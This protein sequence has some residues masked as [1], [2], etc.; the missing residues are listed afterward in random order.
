MKP[1]PRANAALALAL[2]TAAPAAAQDLLTNG[3]FEADPYDNGWAQLGATQFGG[4]APGSTKA[5]SFPALSRIGQN[6]TGASANWQLDFY[7][8]VKNTTNRAFS[9][10]V[11]ATANSAAN[12]S[13]ATIN[14]RYQSGQFNT[15]SGP[16][17]AWSSD[18]G[19]GSVAFSTDANND[20]DFDDAGDVKNVYRMRLTGSGW[21][22]GNG[23]YK[24]Q[25]SNANETTFSRTTTD[26]NRYQNGS[27]NTAV[28]GAFIFNSLFGSNPG[29][30]VDD[31]T[32]ENIV[33]PD[34]PNLAVTSALPIFGT[35]P[36]GATGVTSRNVTVQNTGAANN[37]TITAAAFTGA[38]ASSFSTTATFPI[39]IAPGAT[40]DIPVDFNPGVAK[41]AFSA[42]LELT[43]DDTS[44]AVTPVNLPVH[45]YTAGDSLITDGTFEPLPFPTPWITTGTVSAVAGLRAGSATAAALAGPASGGVNSTAGLAVIGP[46]DWTLEFDTL[47]LTDTGRA[48]QLLVHNFGEPNRLDGSTF[49]LRYEAGSFATLSGTT[50]WVSRPVLGQMIPSLDAN[51]DGDYD[52][53]GD[54]KNVYRIRLSGS[55]WASAAA[56]CSI[57]VSE[58]NAPA[59]TRFDADF[60]SFASAGAL[61]SAPTS[62]LFSTAI[63]TNPGFVV[64]NV[65]MTAGAPA[66]VR[67]YVPVETVSTDGTGITLSWV[68]DGVSSYRVWASEN[69][70]DWT[71]LD[72]D[73]PGP[74]YTDAFTIDRSRRF[75]RVEKQ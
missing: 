47:I 51:T 17:N 42:V 30:Y 69:L 62:F 3:N 63:P 60:V 21:G 5:V 41:G 15:F 28:P 9:L 58:A 44:N 38:N 18:L 25:L 68:A 43:S 7:F 64:D 73:L 54:V 53:E 40:A 67:V 10:S 52:D 59:Y 49:Q 26:L 8:A 23:T 19:L 14:L 72:A 66:L 13:V 75:F 45:L 1:M 35:L 20:G 24:I 70:V 12:T 16:L 61:S 50:T 31:V 65:I 37:L 39:V 2:L 55:G 57:A 71:V 74:I 48:F 4:L 27:G 46:A 32:F 33:L 36:V 22:T 6:L 29:F 34:D 56:T 11:N